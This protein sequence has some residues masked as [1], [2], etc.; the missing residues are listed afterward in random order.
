ML[1][2]IMKFIPRFLGA[3]PGTVQST[4][5]IMIVVALIGSNLL[6]L[7]SFAYFSAASSLVSALPFAEMFGET[8]GQ[9][10]T[11]L[12]AENKKLRKKNQELVAQRKQFRAKVRSARVVSKRIA[13]RTAQNVAHDMTTMVAEAT[14]YVGIAFVVASTALDV[15][16]GCDT[17]RDVNEIFD[18]LEDKQGR[19]DEEKVCGAQVPSAEEVVAKI[20]RDV[21]ETI[22]QAEQ[23]VRERA[24]KFNEDLGGTIDQSMRNMEESAQNFKEILG[25]TIYEIFH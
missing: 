12:E 7:T 19:V 10:Q 18:S 22:G 2:V 16:D 21:G 14:P 11:K 23:N 20:K 15:R 13:Q 24:Q 6:T 17:M 4:L 25:G 3:A 5:L 1:G 8:P 9:R